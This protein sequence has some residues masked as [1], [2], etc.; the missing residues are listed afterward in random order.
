EHVHGDGAAEVD[1][2]ELGLFGRRD[3]EVGVA[4]ALG[5]DADLLRGFAD[6]RTEQEV[7][8]EVDDLGHG[9]GLAQ[10]WPL[11]PIRLLTGVAYTRRLGR[12]PGMRSALLG[13]G[14]CLFAAACGG[15]EP[16]ISAELDTTS[17]ASRIP[18]MGRWQSFDVGSWNV[19]WFGNTREGPS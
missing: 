2:H 5:V 14:L 1:D 12:V 16:D 15:A 7:R 6:L 11:V 18:K 3:D 8:D 4:H 9:P 13:S 17:V 10:V 19:E